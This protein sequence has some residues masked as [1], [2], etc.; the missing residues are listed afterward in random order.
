MNHQQLIDNWTQWD[1]ATQLNNTEAWLAELAAAQARV[2]KLERTA[3]EY[4][5]Q[6]AA[7]LQ[8]A[9]AA[10]ALNDTLRERCELL[11]RAAVALWQLLSDE[12]RQL[13]SVAINAATTQTPEPAD[14]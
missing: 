14:S 10:E 9:E 12:H 2:A 6:M 1:A 7:I 11:S 5:Q 3:A 8:R 4:V 13:L